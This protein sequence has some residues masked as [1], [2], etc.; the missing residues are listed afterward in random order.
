M[1]KCL[2]FDWLV[3]RGQWT[4]HMVRQ[5]AMDTWLIE[6]MPI[7]GKGPVEIIMVFEGCI[8]VGCG[9]VHPKNPFPSADND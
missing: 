9:D 2:G 1:G 3:G 5:R 7:R 6:G 4:V 8:K